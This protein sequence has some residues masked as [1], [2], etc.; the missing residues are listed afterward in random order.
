MVSII[1]LWK[2]MKN[3]IGGS[4]MI[5]AATASTPARAMVPLDT[6]DSTLGRVLSDSV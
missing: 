1:R 2:M 4:R 3:R 5:R 6:W